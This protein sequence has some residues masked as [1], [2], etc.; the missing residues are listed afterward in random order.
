MASRYH[1]RCEEANHVLAALER[2]FLSYLRTSLALTNFGVAY[3]LL[4]RTTTTSGPPEGNDLFFRSG[5]PIAV[6]FVVAGVA[7]VLL[8]AW[9]FYRQQNSLS[10][11]KIRKAGWDLSLVF[12]I[13]AVVSLPNVPARSKLTAYEMVTMVFA[14]VVGIGAQLG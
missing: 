12:G 8:G 2:T 4:F 9:R 14:A 11:G 13:V 1:E 5:I 3:A 10:R 6:V 7:V